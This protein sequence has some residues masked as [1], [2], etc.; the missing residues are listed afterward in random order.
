MRNLRLVYLKRG[1]LRCHS[2]NL[3][4]STYTKTEDWYA[5]ARVELDG[6]IDLELGSHPSEHRESSED[7]IAE[8]MV[9]V[10]SASEREETKQGRARE[11]IDHAMDL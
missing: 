11:Y 4:R 1:Q 8:Y 3:A 10:F 9:W 5:I 6:R 2:H 7:R